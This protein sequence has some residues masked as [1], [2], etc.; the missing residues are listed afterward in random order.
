MLKLP[1]KRTKSKIVIVFQFFL[2]YMDV[3]KNITKNI[4]VFEQVL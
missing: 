2:E 1:N 3:I 4:C